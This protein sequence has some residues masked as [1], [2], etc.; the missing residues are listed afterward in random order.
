MPSF[1]CPRCNRLCRSSGE[2]T[3]DGFP[4]PLHV[5]Q[6]DECLTIWEV[7]GRRFETALTW[8][9]S[10]GGPALDPET[11]TPLPLGEGGGTPPGEG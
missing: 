5:Y 3:A 7:E 11:L 8:A 6:C 9:A 10:S 1:P 2:V 4:Q